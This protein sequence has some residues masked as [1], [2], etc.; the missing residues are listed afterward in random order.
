[1]QNKSLSLIKNH[2]YKKLLQSQQ[3][4]TPA[5][6]RRPL[7]VKDCSL[8]DHDPE[9]FELLKKENIRQLSGIELI[10]SENFTYRYV[11]EC[12]GSALNNTYSED[13]S[14]F[15]KY[16]RTNRHDDIENLCIQRALEAYRLDPNEWSVNVQPYSG[17]PA[18]FAVFNALLLPGD[19]MMGMSLSHGGHLTHGF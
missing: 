16:K 6:K 2:T 4:I 7:P 8:Q 10:A 1:M 3:F 9:I 14:H 13:Y 18:N 15:E 19:K 11:T 5:L 17:S 12:L